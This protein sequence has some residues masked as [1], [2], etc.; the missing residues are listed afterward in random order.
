TVAMPILCVRHECSLCFLS[1]CVNMC[2]F[3]TVNA[4]L[5]VCK[6]GVCVCVC[7]C[8][9]V[10]AWVVFFVLF[11]IFVGEMCSCV[12]VSACVSVCVPFVPCLGENC[13]SVCVCTRGYR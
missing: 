2:M 11:A 13:M 1:L 6:G 5:C 3:V 7:V 8:V 9:C 4:H 10:S 12:C